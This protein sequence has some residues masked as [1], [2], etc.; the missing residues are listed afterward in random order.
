MEVTA[1]EEEFE[2]RDCAVYV[3]CFGS[4]SLL[5]VWF[6]IA[7]TRWQ[8]GSLANARIR[9]L[10]RNGLMRCDAVNTFRTLYF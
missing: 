9:Y 4:F 8:A 7:K 1:I 2:R 6:M 5:T 3:M 10:R